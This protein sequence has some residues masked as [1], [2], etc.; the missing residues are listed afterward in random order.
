MQVGDRSRAA[1][2]PVHHAGVQ[3][4]FA[5]LIRQPAVADRSVVRIVLDDVDARD[6][7][8]ERVAARFQD[9]HCSFE[10]TD[11]TRLDAALWHSGAVDAGDY[12]WASLSQW[13]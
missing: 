10:A 5:F 8:V 3:F 13:G 11:S 7:C 9:L 2:R 12:H 1:R 4:D 6:D